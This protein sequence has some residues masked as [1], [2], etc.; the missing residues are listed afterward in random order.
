MK[1]STS[2]TS[3]TT[4]P[5]A[6]AGQVIALKPHQEGKIPSYVE[7][8]SSSYK[9]M[10]AEIRFMKRIIEDE[11]IGNQEKLSI[12]LEFVKVSTQML[13]IWAKYALALSH[14]KTGSK[15][16]ISAGFHSNSATVP[17][18]RS[19]FDEGAEHGN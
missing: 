4:A 9:R 18:P 5:P 19:A 1:T 7:E 10:N 11:N 8:F 15:T 14:S 12:L 17:S 13:D 6:E 3:Q 16:A 2:P